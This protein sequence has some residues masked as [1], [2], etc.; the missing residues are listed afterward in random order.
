MGMMAHLI[1]S[2]SQHQKNSEIR[3]LP[4]RLLLIAVTCYPSHHF[5]MNHKQVQNISKFL[6]NYS[7]EISMSKI[8]VIIK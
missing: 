5:H 6:N 7:S 3:I 8:K 4:M 1:H 2:Q